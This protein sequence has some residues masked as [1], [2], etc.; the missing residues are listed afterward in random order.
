MKQNE[1]KRNRKKMAKKKVSQIE[2]VINNHQRLTK[3]NLM[4][5]N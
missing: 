1:I 3:G 2:T 4:D 5:L